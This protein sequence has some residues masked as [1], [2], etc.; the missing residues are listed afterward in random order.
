[1]NVVIKIIIIYIIYLVLH[2]ILIHT[3]SLVA[4]NIL[5]IFTIPTSGTSTTEAYTDESLTTFENSGTRNGSRLLVLK[6]KIAEWGG[7]GHTYKK[8]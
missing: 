1:M 8:K 2:S 5:K 6:K 7:G 3:S 4:L